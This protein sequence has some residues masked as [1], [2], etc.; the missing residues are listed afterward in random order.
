MRAHELIFSPLPP[1]LPQLSFMVACVVAAFFMFMAL[2]CSVN[3]DAGCLT[4]LVGG[5][6]T[7]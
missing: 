6:R 3:D 4:K 2:V 1:S 5:N 7:A